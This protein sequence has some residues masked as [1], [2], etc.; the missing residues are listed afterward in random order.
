MTDEQKNLFLPLDLQHFAED[1]PEDQ[2]D[3]NETPEDDDEK[4]GKDDK[5]GDQST[6]DNPEDKHD[7]PKKLDLT[8]EQ[9]DAIVKDR[10]ERD[11][12]ARQREEDEKKR[13]Q[14][15]EKGN[16]KDLYENVKGELDTLR[17]EALDAKKE[18]LLAKAGYDEAQV[19]K[20]KKYLVG[21]DDDALSESLDE[22]KADIP[23]KSKQKDYGDPSAGNGQKTP[24]KKTNLEE[25][26]KS[27][28]QRLKEKG[29]IRGASNK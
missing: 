20:Y 3:P 12:R 29:K 28:Y 17:E 21:D 10:L 13:E 8:Q 22:L 6:G 27:A 9:L 16:Y 24:P 14:D 19:S 11:R 25:K 23:P 7:E 18:S 2:D 26:G 1:N 5:G 15:E 4:G